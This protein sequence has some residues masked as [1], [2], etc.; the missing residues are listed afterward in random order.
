MN[1]VCDHKQHVVPVVV[2]FVV[3]VDVVVLFYLLDN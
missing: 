2:T 1:C 3:V